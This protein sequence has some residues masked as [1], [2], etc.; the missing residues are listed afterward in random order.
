MNTLNGTAFISTR[1]DTSYNAACDSRNYHLSTGGSIS[2]F[3]R[4]GPS[5]T[6]RSERTTRLAVI[7][8]EGNKSFRRQAK[9]FRRVLS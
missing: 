2:I 3:S 5:S 8:V 4:A 9:V 7:S 6:H 1:C